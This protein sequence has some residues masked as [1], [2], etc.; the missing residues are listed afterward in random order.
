MK[1]LGCANAPAYPKS[2]GCCLEF[3]SGTGGLIIVTF[4]EAADKTTPIELIGLIA[5][6]A[7]HV[8]QKC[9]KFMQDD[10][11]SLE[12]EAYGVQAITQSLLMKF[13]ELRRPDLF[14]G[15]KKRAKVSRQ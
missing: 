5:H 7:T 15:S 8:V 2:A 9:C 11:P 1:R 13:I 14:G 3:D 12:F 6:E 10:S 4:S